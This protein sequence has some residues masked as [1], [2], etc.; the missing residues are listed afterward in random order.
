MKYRFVLV[1]C[2]LLFSLPAFCQVPAQTVP[3]FEFSRPDKTMF[4]DKDLPREKMLFFVFF[5]PDCEH[6]QQAVKNI[7][8]QADSLHNV[9]VYLISAEDPGKINRFINTF[10]AHLKNKKNVLVLHDTLNQFMTRFKPRRYPAMFLYSKQKQ[11]VGYEDNEAS[12]FRFFKEI[13]AGK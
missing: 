12:V 8:Q 13:T 6:C 3:A 11:L 7:D 9:A 4:T 5:D 1:G 10:A 2:W